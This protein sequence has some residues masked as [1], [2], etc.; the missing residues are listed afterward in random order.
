[1]TSPHAPVA[2]SPRP[3]GVLLGD[4]DAR[5]TAVALSPVT[6][7]WDGGVFFEQVAAAFLTTGHRVFVYDTLSLL[8][9]GDDLAALTDRWA[10]VIE[11]VGPIDVLV[12]NALGGAVVQGLL[13]REWARHAAAVV[14][15]G[16]TVADRAL[17]EKLESISCAVEERGMAEAVRLK[18]ELVLGPASPQPPDAPDA[19]THPDDGPAGFRLATGMRLL[20]DVD[21]ARTV[22]AFPGRLLHLYGAESRLV[23]R[24]HLAVGP[25]HRCVEIP[26]AGMRPHADRPDLT[27]EVLTR[28]LEEEGT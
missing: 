2:P 5:R 20:H 21:L 22:R 1:M 10:R 14:L 8:R 25:R 19:G 28:F 13:D 4:G 24:V 27:R 3:V 11:D 23:Q 15:S 18:D 26:G 7:G 16:P 12:G 17:N 6:L 9:E